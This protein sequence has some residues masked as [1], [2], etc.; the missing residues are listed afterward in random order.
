M[1]RHARASQVTISLQV[2]QDRVVCA[3]RDNG[4]GFDTGITNHNRTDS[5]LGLINLRERIAALQGSLEVESSPGQGSCV[6]VTIPL[7]V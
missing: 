6:R 1:I 7:T 5:G 2:F 3:I 4:V